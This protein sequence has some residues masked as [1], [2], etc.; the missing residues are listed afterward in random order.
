M[1]AA[2]TEAGKCSEIMS[3]AFE[4]RL[5]D[6]HDT[7]LQSDCDRAPA[8]VSAATIG[9]FFRCIAISKGV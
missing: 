3:L 8:F 7:H 9:M 4:H 2:A 6:T 5:S 1:M